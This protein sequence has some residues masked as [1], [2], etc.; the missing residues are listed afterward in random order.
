MIGQNIGLE[1]LLPLALESLED[2]LFTQGDLYAGD[3]LDMVLNVKAEFWRSNPLYKKDLE[4]ILDGTIK[5]LERKL[6]LLCQ[7]D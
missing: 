7:S 2:N 6:R 5:D 3:L 4:N 1:Y